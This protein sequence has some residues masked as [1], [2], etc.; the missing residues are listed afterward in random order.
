MKYD[1]EISI[2]VGRSRKE[3]KWKNKEILWSELV[4]KLSET[5]RTA[6]T[7]NEYM[8]SPKGRQ[9]EIK[10][11]GGFVGGYLSQGVRKVDSVQNRT[12]ITLDIDHAKSDNDIFDSFDML[13]GNAAVIYSTHK[14]TPEI[15]KL[16]LVI[17]INRPVFTDEYEAIS[18]RI[19][20][21]LGI[22]DFDD[23]TFQ[24]SR[25]MYFPSTS[26]D[27]E[28]LFQKLDAPWLDADQILNTYFDWK[29]SSSWPISDRVNKIVA[30]GIKK[31]GDPLEKPGLIGAFCRCYNIHEAIEKYLQD[32]YEPCAM[33]NRYTY[34]LGSTAAGLITYDDKFAFSHHG[35]DPASG[36]L[37][38]AFDLVR[39]H[40]F[41]LKDED[42]V[43][44]TPSNRL[45]SYKEM[46]EFCSKD[47]T[48]RKQLGKEKIQ[49]AIEDFEGIEL[50]DGEIDT[51]WT[52]NLDIDGKGRIRS[53]IDN[54][55]II[56]KNDYKLKVKLAFNKFNNKCIAL[57]NLPWRKINKNNNELRDLDDAGLRHYMEATYGI[58]G[59]NK[60]YDASALIMEENAFHPV[61]DYLNTLEW[62]G[63]P[64]I[65]TLLID[66]LGAEDTEY[67]R[68]VTRKA[69][70]ACVARIKNPGCKFDYVLTLVGKQGVGK[71]TILKK[72]GGKWFSD[73]FTT[74]QGK[75]AVEQIQGY[76]LIE[77]AELS[78]L[79]KAEVETVKHFMSKQEDVFRPAYGRKTETHPRQCI[80]FG[81]TNNSDFLTDSTG[82][83]RF[84]AVD[85]M[86]VEPTKNIF[87]E[88]T[89]EVVNQVWAEA[90]HLY[91]QGEKL[92]LN[93]DMEGMA[94]KVQEQH[95]KVDERIGLVEDYLNTPIPEDWYDMDVFDRTNYIHNIDSISQ[96]GTILRNR[97]SVI[98]VWTEL[99]N[100][101][102]KDL[103][104]RKSMEI[105]N[106]LKAIKGWEMYKKSGGVGRIKG[107]GR[108][109]IYI[110]SV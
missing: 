38:N 69:F 44:N 16:R 74:V 28:Y 80:F 72:L 51:S 90:L 75:E 85:T 8:A 93:K 91:Q 61:M 12:V 31:Q 33:E 79:R 70:V 54:I 65:D 60:I 57:G 50:K 53:S 77:M 14:H 26:K 84:W 98:E 95:T 5:T 20:G 110:K 19:A 45:P 37:C 11:V 42:A 49:S 39:I 13:Y 82:N 107:Y 27:G 7:H 35:T 1:G 63:Q 36:K 3:T 73:S 88:L 10:D 106:I 58:T 68:A 48:V 21:D 46:V 105:N 97:I 59:G 18:R 94:N 67:V 30:R 55:L 109:R 64:R 15:P 56:L 17:P 6:E 108:Q 92:Y 86:V 87:T 29:D 34:K 81:T 52:E 23:T 104:R 101:Q 71:S 2:A 25:L 100:G 102:K 78:G 32:E 9:S 40:L 66:Y 89:K 62:D 41:G 83:R 96:K 43:P 4:N 22:N 24:P 99:F 76:W 103:D 47:K